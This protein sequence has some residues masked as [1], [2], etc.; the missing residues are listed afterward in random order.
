MEE[1]LQGPENGFD[2][3][4]KNFSRLPRFYLRLHFLNPSAPGQLRDPRN[5]SP[6]PAPDLI[7]W[8]VFLD[9][10]QF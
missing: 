6:L 2:R 1:L 8:N 4:R 7:G 5:G 3:A 10:G 9:L